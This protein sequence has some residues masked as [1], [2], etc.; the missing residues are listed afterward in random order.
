MSYIISKED[1]LSMAMMQG[2]LDTFKAD[3]KEQLQKEADVI[4][5]RTIEELSK[6]VK[7][8]VESADDYVWQQKRVHLSW[9]LK[10]EDV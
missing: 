7:A 1:Q 5:E 4:I 3:L 9:C 6:R 10:R 2:I 8:K